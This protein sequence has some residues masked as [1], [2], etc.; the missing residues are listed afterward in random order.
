MADAG[1][2][3]RDKVTVVT[4]GSTGIGKGCVQVFGTWTSIRQVYV[5]QAC[6][7]AIHKLQVYKCQQI[8]RVFYLLSA[9][10]TEWGQLKLQLFCPFADNV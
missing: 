8:C 2:R 10:N 7:A 1:V 3:Y 5:G 9:D 6:C 4:G